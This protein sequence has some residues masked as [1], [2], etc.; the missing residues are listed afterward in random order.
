MKTA[1][2]RGLDAL[3]PE[4]GEEILHLELSRIA[5]GGEQPRKVFRDNSL[6]ELAATRKEKGVL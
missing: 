5:P 3:I 1:L 4:K 2:G 6:K